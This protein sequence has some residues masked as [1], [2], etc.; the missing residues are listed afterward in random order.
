M[1]SSVNCASKQI[2]DRTRGSF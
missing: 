1:T 2:I